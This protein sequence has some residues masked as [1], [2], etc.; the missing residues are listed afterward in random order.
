M[1]NLPSFLFPAVLC[2]V[3]IL[4]AF[5][6]WVAKRRR[7]TARALKEAYE[8]LKLKKL[9]TETIFGDLPIGLE[10]YTK[11]GILAGL[12][13]YA[14]QI[15]GIVDKNEVIGSA[16]IWE[17]PVIPQAVKDAFRQQEKVQLECDYD[18]LS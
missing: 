14:C 10:V 13:E 11:E 4:S 17:N 8:T 7:S 6:I 16:P 15:F 1:S 9:R 3:F 18:F 5:L 12:N 2:A